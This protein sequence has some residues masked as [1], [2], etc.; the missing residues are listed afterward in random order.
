MQAR[1]LWA[2]GGHADKP[3]PQRQ[4]GTPRLDTP[5][6]GQPGSPERWHLSAQGRGGS[7]TP[8][9]MGNRQTEARDVDA[10]P[11]AKPKQRTQPDLKTVLL[12]PQPR[13]ETLTPARRPLPRRPPPRLE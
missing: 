11:N 5:S 4:A 13:T 3:T 7:G 9:R 10:H 1:G 8:P 2:G 12:A 6:P